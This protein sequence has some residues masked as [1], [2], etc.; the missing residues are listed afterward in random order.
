MGEL[1]IVIAIIAIMVALLLPALKKAKENTNRI[2]CANKLKQLGNCFVM[3][4]SDSN[5]IFPYNNYTPYY[6]STYWYVRMLDIAGIEWKTATYMPDL[7][8][9]PQTKDKAQVFSAANVSYGYNTCYLSARYKDEGYGG[10][11][12][13]GNKATRIKNPS[14]ITMLSDNMD[15]APDSDPQ[16]NALVSYHISDSYPGNM[17]RNGANVL[18][19]DSHVELKLQSEL[20]Y[21]T[22][23]L[24]LNGNN[25]WFGYGYRNYIDE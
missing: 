24:A 20:L 13:A 1:I 6:N 10:L 12:S 3:Y 7:L 25:K 2:A 18:F 4:L 9:C 14:S 16:R 19:C 11:Y 8:T 23:T 21:S 22:S 17:H 15:F 5:E